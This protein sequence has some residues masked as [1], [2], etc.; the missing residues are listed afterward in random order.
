MTTRLVEHSRR[1]LPPQE[2]ALHQ[3]RMQRNSG[4]AWDRDLRAKTKPLPS[5]GRGLL[6]LV[7][8]LGA[9]LLQNLVSEINFRKISSYGSPVSLLR[10]CA[11]NDNA[12]PLSSCSR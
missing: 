1:Y 12:A 6:C 11:S 3:S 9:H 4:K 5:Q 2:R 8:L 10:R 7:K